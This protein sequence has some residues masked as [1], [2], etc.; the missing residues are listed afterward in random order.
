MYVNVVMFLALGLL[1]AGRRRDSAG[2][3]WSSTHLP[4]S[5]SLWCSS[6]QLALMQNEHCYT[7]LSTMQCYTAF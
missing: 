5:L 4:L 1:W 7:M 2:R 6:K 3:T